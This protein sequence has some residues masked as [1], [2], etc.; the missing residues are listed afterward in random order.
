M[1]KYVLLIICLFAT[2][3]GVAQDRYSIFSLSGDIKY[4]SKNGFEW[5]KAKKKMPLELGDYLSIP[6][7]GNVSILDNNTRCVHYSLHEG[8]YKV[9]T[10]ITDALQNRSALMKR[11]GEELITNTTSSAPKQISFRPIGGVKMG[12]SCVEDS[13]ASFLFMYMNNGADEVFVKANN[14]LLFRRV[15]IS[16]DYLTFDI[17]N[18]STNGYY[19]NIAIID[20]NSK[21]IN[22]C[23]NISE[24]IDDEAV[25]L[26][27]FVPSGETISFRDFPFAAS[28]KD[29]FVLF[30]T[31]KEFSVEALQSILD[32]G[33]DGSSV[34]INIADFCVGVELK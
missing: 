32:K 8:S 6:Q 29:E 4:K 5:V 9:R 17:T 33:D 21:K 30:G 13:I 34:N 12:S 16:K 15:Y 27:L 23:Y 11:L 24:I 3:F 22:I 19:Y 20:R 2:I 25:E 7:K 26:S 1:K 28:K 31:D 18:N 14:Q 10:I